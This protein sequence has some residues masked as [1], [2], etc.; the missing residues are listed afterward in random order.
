MSS[1]IG[2]G[3]MGRGGGDA[4]FHVLPVLEGVLPIRGIDGSTGEAIPMG[5]TSGLREASDPYRAD[6]VRWAAMDVPSIM[7]EE[8]L[9]RLRDEYRIPED[10]ELILPGP[11]ERACFPRLGCTALHLNAFVSGMRLPLHPMFRRIL[12]AYDLAPTQVTPNGWSQMVGSMYLWFRHSF[13]M[14]MPLQ[15]FQSVYQPRKLPRKKGKE[16]EVGWYYFCPWG[17]H[18]PLVTGCPSSIKQWKESWFWVKG[19]WQRVYDDPEPDLN[20][21]S[22]YGIAS[23]LPRCE[24]SRENTDVLRSIYEADTKGRSYNF[25]L[26]RQRCL[27]ELGLVASKADMDQGRRP[28]P[29][30]AKLAKQRPRTLV[31][32]SAED[33]S[34]RK[35]IEDLSRAGNKE[36]AEASK[37]IEVDDAPEAEA[38]VPL[39]RKRKARPSGPGTSQASAAAVEIVDPP[40]ISVPPLQ[41]TLTVN[42]AGEVVLEGASKSTPTPEGETGGSYDSK[43]R[44]RELIGAPGARIPDDTLRSVPF[45][46]SMGAQAFKKYFTPKWEEFSSHGELEDVLEASLASAIR[47]SAMQMKVLGEFRNRM[48]EQKKRAAEASKADK[49]HQQ[50]LEG[51]KAALESAEIAYKQM[52]ADL[53]ESDSNLLNMTKQLDNANAAQR[54]AAEALEAANVEKRRLQEEAKSRD[55]EVSSLRQELANAAKGR[56]EAEAGK[57]EVEA[58]LKEVEAK[59]ANAEADFVANFHN[60]EAYSNFSDYFARVGQQEVLT[61]LRTD[62]PDFDVKNLETRFPPPDA[63]GEEDD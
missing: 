56:E 18:K 29:T 13:G 20:V 1:G 52:E 50:A 12:R 55:E 15:V 23:P 44:L 22:V 57:E 60:T 32:G 58:R 42:T 21:P 61:A 19:N 2:G 63:E 62:H 16:E 4:P 46:P 33:S 30:L 40:T 25:I 36:A 39:S 26:N 37:I 7:K 47:A 48:Q 51:L 59:L 17:S 6:V 14:E 35:V 3:S 41:R 53:R 11:N 31:P 38:E 54:V 49:E 28:R 5:T 43:R 24:L 8:D 45:Y 34:Q 9:T 27:V 10:I